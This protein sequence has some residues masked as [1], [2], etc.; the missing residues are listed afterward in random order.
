MKRKVFFKNISGEGLS[1]LEIYL[2]FLDENNSY[3]FESVEGGEKWAKYSIIGLPTKNKINLGENPLDEIDAFMKSHQTEKI[4]G[5]P[6]FSGGLVGFFSYDTIRL[7]ENK[8]K[9]SKKPKLD[10]DEISLM[11]SDEIIVYD[12]YDKRLFI[13]VNDYEKNEKNANIRIEEILKKIQSPYT[14]KEQPKKNNIKF[15][16]SVSKENHLKNV[17]I[18]KDYILEGDVMQVVY[19]QEFSSPFTG[20]PVSLYKALRKLNPSPYMYFLKIDDLHIVGASPEIL[21]RLQNNQVTVRPIAGTVKRGKTDAE[22]KELSEKLRNDE[23]EIAEHLMLIDLGR[24]DVGRIA[25][26]GSVKTTDQMVI[27]KYSHVMHLVSN[28]IGD[29]KENQSAIDVLKA[30]LPAGTLSGAPK[31]R[32]MEIIDELEPDRRGIY[33]GAIGYLSWTG[34]MDTA[35]AIRTAVIKNDIIKVR[36]GGGIVHDS[37]P[38]SEYQESLNK[39]QS[40]FNAIEEM[41]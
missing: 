15:V 3:F 22:D 6:D 40:I 26:T 19:G 25:K 36:A 2:K 9:D 37:D 17:E 20:S 18:I 21:V 10:Y 4:E 12:N 11:I 35:I 1:P 41:D 29:L 30:T 32:A 23:K 24:N 31:V 27:E 16:S 38:E 8:L 14:E 5:L 39:A 7:I 33:G 28:V 34:N 13:I